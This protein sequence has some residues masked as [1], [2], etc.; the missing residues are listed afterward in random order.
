VPYATSPT[1]PVRHDPHQP[2]PMLQQVQPSPHTTPDHYFSDGPLA[3][4]DSASRYLSS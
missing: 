1:S 4:L 2:R 3:G